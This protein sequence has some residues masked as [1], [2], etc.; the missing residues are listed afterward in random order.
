ML[1]ALLL[2]AAAPAYANT[3]EAQTSDGIDAALVVTARAMLANSNSQ[4]D[5]DIVD[6]SLMSLRIAP[7]VKLTRGDATIT[8]SNATTRVE[9]F[10]D[11]RSDRWQNIARLEAAY[12]VSAATTLRLL[13]ERSD[14]I[15]TAEASRADEWEVGGEIEQAFGAASRVSLGARWRERR[16]DDLDQSRGNGPRFDAEY[17]HRFAANH[18]AFLRGRYESIASATDRR[19][20]KRWT[21]SASYQR[22]LA[23]DLSLRPSLTWSETEFA[24]RPLIGGGF[25]RD[26]VLSPELSLT[27][28]PGRWRLSADARYIARQST[29]PQFD[30]SG[31]RFTLEVGYVF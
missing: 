12:T 19:D 5:D 14:N 11:G 29:D 23:R 8:L 21:A 1:A 28:S 30:R 4:V 2:S 25:R 26:R 22:P 7:S 24:G 10:S 9:Y 27:Y 18:Y 17:R 3:A 20:V 15:L 31:T 16:Y 13:G 6:G